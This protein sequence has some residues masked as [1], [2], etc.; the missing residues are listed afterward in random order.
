MTDAFLRTKTPKLSNEANVLTRKY[1]DPNAHKRD[2]RRRK[3]D[4]YELKMVNY[5]IRV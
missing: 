2:L 3:I 5:N 1:N 4:L